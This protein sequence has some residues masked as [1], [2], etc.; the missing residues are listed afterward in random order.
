[1]L[2]KNK[3]YCRCIR[4]IW[5]FS[6]N[7]GDSQYYPG[8]DCCHDLCRHNSSKKS[9]FVRECFRNKEKFWIQIVYGAYQ[10]KIEN[11]ESQ[12]R[13]LWKTEY[14]NL[15]LQHVWK[16]RSCWCCPAYFCHPVPEEN[17]QVIFPQSIILFRRTTWEHGTR[18]PDTPIPLKKACPM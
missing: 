6:L 18:S 7:R 5:L 14:K 8:R 11:N 3:G 10:R 1:M 17:P 9:F 15:P 4:R 13:Y 16:D 2:W 12:R